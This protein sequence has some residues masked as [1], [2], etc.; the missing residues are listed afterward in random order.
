M[1]P[2]EILHTERANWRYRHAVRAHAQRLPQIS[3]LP[4]IPL[5]WRLY[6]YLGGSVFL[7]VAKIVSSRS[8]NNQAF[9]PESTGFPFAVYSINRPFR[10]PDEPTVDRIVKT[11]E[12][13]NIYILKIP[14]TSGW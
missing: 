14:T 5:A 11:K 13:W 2:Q 10:N 9:G 4:P 3:P 7:S 8:T 12:K 6:Q 1:P